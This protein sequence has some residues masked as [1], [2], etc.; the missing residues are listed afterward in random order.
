MFLPTIIKKI[1][2]SPFVLCRRSAAE[3]G[4]PRLTG[5]CSSGMVFKEFLRK[6]ATWF[7]LLPAKLGAGLPLQPLFHVA[8]PEGIA[9]CACCL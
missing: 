7:A 8:S 2:F 1:L 5:V 3:L 4:F 9:S 6:T